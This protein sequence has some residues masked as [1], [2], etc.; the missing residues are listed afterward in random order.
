MHRK[1]RASERAKRY[2]QDVRG[3]V[4]LSQVSEHGHEP[5]SRGNVG[6]VQHGSVSVQVRGRLATTPSGQT[7]SGPRLTQSRNTAANDGGRRSPGT[8]GKEG[9]E[10]GRHWRQPGRQTC[11]L[12][13][14]GLCAVMSPGGLYTMGGKEGR[15]GHYPRGGVSRAASTP[16]NAGL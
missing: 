7:G 5:A 13:V 2:V 15:E 14:R 4:G 10:G 6:H 11:R 9:G 12:P 3:A 1:A 8:G 16:G